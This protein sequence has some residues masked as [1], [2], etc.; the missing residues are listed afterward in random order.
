MSDENSL[1]S[2][3]YKIFY[4]DE[5]NDNWCFDLSVFEQSYFLFHM[6]TTQFY[7]VLLCLSMTLVT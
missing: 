2:K 7:E 3:L 1:I 5:Q 4:Y 6:I